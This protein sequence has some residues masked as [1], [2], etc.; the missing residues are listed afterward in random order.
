M[1]GKTELEFI[2]D[3]KPHPKNASYISLKL[4]LKLDIQRW[5]NEKINKL[6]QKIESLAIH[7][8]GSDD[9]I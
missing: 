7:V 9:N 2:R 5:D 8:S 4:I 1:I 3:W 6:Q